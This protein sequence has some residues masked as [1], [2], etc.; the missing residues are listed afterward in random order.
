MMCPVNP[1]Y[2]SHIC[3]IVT[4]ST[5]HSPYSSHLSLLWTLILI[6]YLQTPPISLRVMDNNWEKQWDGKKKL[7]PP[8]V[9]PLFRD[10]IDLSIVARRWIEVAQTLSGPAHVH[11]RQ[12]QDSHQC[13]PS[14][15]CR[16]SSQWSR[17]NGS[18]FQSIKQW[19]RSGLFGGLT[20]STTR[21]Y[22]E[23]SVCPQTLWLVTQGY[24]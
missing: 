2:S 10:E 24:C 19:Y 3:H 12:F 8:E 16:A 6:N 5:H 7:S 17:Q 11:F 13:V 15:L 9:C 23:F 21:G 1:S 22:F 4:S 14:S 18:Y 20:T